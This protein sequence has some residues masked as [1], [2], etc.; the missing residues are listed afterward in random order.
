MMGSGGS[1][2]QVRVGANGGMDYKSGTDALKHAALEMFQF[3]GSAA[4]KASSVTFR[5]Q[6]VADAA[7]S[8]RAQRFFAWSRPRQLIAISIFILLFF[9]FLGGFSTS[10]QTAAS[11]H[12]IETLNILRDRYGQS[13]AS[14]ALCK[15]MLQ[16]AKEKLRML[17]VCTY[18]C[19]Q[20]VCISFLLLLRQFCSTHAINSNSVRHTR[21]KLK[22]CSTHA[23]K[24]KRCSTH[25]QS[26]S[27]SVCFHFLFVPRRKKSQ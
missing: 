11:V 25:T 8:F 18:R 13:L 26:N 15:E 23:I 5:K 2:A 4:T 14:A 22:Q 19:Q 7:A 16:A 17:S 24:L 21:Y 20:P 9:S 6:I 1:S 12:D 10:T 3:A 27:N